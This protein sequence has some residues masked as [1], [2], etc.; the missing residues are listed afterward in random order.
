MATYI[1]DNLPC[2][3][4]LAA[5]LPSSPRSVSGALLLVDA[6]DPRLAGMLRLLQGD[7]E[8][9]T[10]HVA[11]FNAER[12]GIGEDLIGWPLLR[13][14]FYMDTHEHLLLKGIA[15]ILSGE[16]WFPRTLLIRYLEHTRVRTT[17]PLGDATLTRKQAEILQLIASGDT[18]SRIAERL[19]VTKNTV[20]THIYHLFRKINAA[21]RIQAVNW[22]KAHLQGTPGSAARL[23]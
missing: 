3:C 15:A 8:R 14:L 10:Q 23:S 17:A 2:E 19:G 16:F 20:K 13:G 7:I 18:N 9:G 4:Q 21:N 6:Q 5:S 12:D 1:R 11:I 22:E